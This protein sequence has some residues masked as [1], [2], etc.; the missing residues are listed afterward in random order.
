VDG[1]IKMNMSA[2]LIVSITIQLIAVGIFIG[3]YKTT[4]TFMQK[5]Q[6]EIKQQIK[7]DKAE[8]KADMKK[9]NNVLERI[10]VAENS[11]SAAHHRVDAL[12]ERFK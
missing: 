8:L 2:E 12:E 5:Q 4:I 10:A 3:V 11:I 6:E 9:Y 1:E 7:E